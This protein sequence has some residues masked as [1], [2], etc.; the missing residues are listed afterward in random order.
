[1]NSP[2]RRKMFLFLRQKLVLRTKKAKT[3][4]SVVANKMWLE[5]AKERKINHGLILILMD[6]RL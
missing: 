6:S 3:F 4:P 1:M 5:I 2:I